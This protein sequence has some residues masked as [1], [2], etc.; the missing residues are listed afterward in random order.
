LSFSDDDRSSPTISE[1]P[2]LRNAEPAVGSAIVPSWPTSWTPTGSC[3][4]S[5]ATSAERAFVAQLGRTSEA[6]R[7]FSGESK[8][9]SGK[10]SPPR[11]I[12]TSLKGFMP[13][14]HILFVIDDRVLALADDRRRSLKL[15]LPR[16]AGFLGVQGERK[17]AVLTL[18]QPRTCHA[19]G[20]RMGG[21]QDLRPI[22]RVFRPCPCKACRR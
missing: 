13:G 15:A 22:A 1:P 4:P 20:G 5:H 18:G 11:S 2:K 12:S 21:G 6:R 9:S 16:W 3:Q 8:C 10:S 19:G 7:K 17:L 14:D